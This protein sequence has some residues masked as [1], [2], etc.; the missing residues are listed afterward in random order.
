MT[1]RNHREAKF[2]TLFSHWLKANWQSSAAFE[3]K[4]ARDKRFYLSQIKEHQ[5]AALRIAS[6]NL[7]YWKIADT[8]YLMAKPFDNFTLYRVPAYV[9]VLFTKTFYLIPIKNILALIKE[10]KK[11]LTE[12]ETNAIAYEAVKIKN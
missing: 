3:L 4:V 11:S 10:K 12:D 7:L 5:I 8:D 6:S 9:V 2:Q 1:T